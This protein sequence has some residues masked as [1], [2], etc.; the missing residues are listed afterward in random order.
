[1]SQGGRWLRAVLGRHR[2]EQEMADEMAN[3]IALRVGHLVAQGVP[4][5]QAERQARVEFGGVESFKESCR[6][7]RRLHWGD[8]LVRNLRHAV[9]VFAR[10]PGLTATIVATLALG[11]GANVAV[12]S[13][14]DAVLLRPLPYPEPERLALVQTV[15]AREGEVVGNALSQD[16]RAWEALRAASRHTDTAVFSD[17]PSGANVVV[18]DRVEHL[19]QQRLG[20]GFFRVLGVRPLLGRGFSAEEDLPGGPDVA[21][22]SH[23]LWNR[24]FGADPAVINRLIQLRGAPHRVVGVMPATFRTAAEADLWTPLRPSTSGEGEGTNY[25]IVGRLRA[26]TS[27]PVAD[28]EIRALGAQALEAMRVPDDL[29]V[30]LSITPL[31]QGMTSD[32]RLRLWISWLTTWLVL[33][34]GC[35][36][37]AGLLLVHAARRARE[38]ATRMT[39]GGGRAVIIR[40]LL[41]ESLLLGL[42]AGGVGALV[43]YAGM[44]LLRN[45]VTETLGVWQPI[46]VDLRMVLATAGLSL[47]TVVVSGLYPA[48]QATRVSLGAGQGGGD[49]RVAGARSPWPRRLLVVT[50]LALV[51]M[52]LVGAGLMLRTLAHLR[53]LQPGFAPDGLTV[54]TVS[55]QDARYATPERIDRLFTDTL[56]E[57][58]RQPAIEHAA[59]GLSM[60]YQRPLNMSFT[61]V[62][63][64]GDG[65]GRQTTNL[66]YVTSDYFRTLGVPVLRGRTLA[67]GDRVDTTPVAVVNQAFVRA[68]LADLPA[69][70]DAVGARIAIGNVER[71]IVG[72]VGDTQQQRSWGE[73]GPIGALPA[74]FISVAQ[75]SEAFLALVHTWFQ[76][77]WVVRGRGDGREAVSALRAAIATIDPHLPI[78]ALRDVSV[79]RTEVLARERFQATLL[80]LASALGLVLA[81][82]GLGALIASSVTER[83]REMGIR[84]ALGASVGRA[85]RSAAMPGMIMALA[86]LAAGLV[87][88]AIGVRTLRSFVY[89]VTVFDP[90]TYIGV[91]V[92]LLT[93]AA[94]ASILPS[95]RVLR[96]DPA[97]TL[98]AD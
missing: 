25:A 95:L 74:V 38:I 23:G 29:E 81:T 75:T 58:R 87:L 48:F 59:A 98:R 61:R 6:E 42:L 65:L 5:E 96:L 79:L 39:L 18:G 64:E 93:V 1:M 47:L 71:Q 34:L 83:T 78:A 63:L 69:D 15:Y 60:P 37:V 90:A 44:R 22:L 67:R 52:L 91:G 76:P 77:S 14:V 56:A 20:A 84:M 17:W 30:S 88:A 33:L 35:I 9:R 72:V 97:R 41:T 28:A 82:V 3:H 32:L 94:V 12:F 53:G 8:E 2:F 24:L 11:I 40:Q 57:L 16:G 62:G 68:Y 43:G 66:T 45:L 46:G 31:Q 54:A 50:Q 36:N 80:S 27:W 13:V 85:L 19:Q 7:S 55:L 4:R 26:D 51:V 86:G 21:V 92:L 10:T 70:L 73:G 49:L 89:G